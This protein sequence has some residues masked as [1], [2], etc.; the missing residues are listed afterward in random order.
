MIISCC[1]VICTPG[2]FP[3]YHGIRQDHAKMNVWF[4]ILFSCQSEQTLVHFDP[5]QLKIFVYLHN[6]GV[7]WCMTCISLIFRQFQLQQFEWLQGSSR[8]C[9]IVGIWQF[10]LSILQ[11]QVYSA[12]ILYKKAY[13]NMI[14]LFSNNLPQHLIVVWYQENTV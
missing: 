4:H 11:N 10:V 5:S 3:S 14:I 12:E 8:F 1:S 13:C 2:Y 7:I 6:L 9:Y